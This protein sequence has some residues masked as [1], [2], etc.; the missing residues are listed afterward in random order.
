MESVVLEMIGNVAVLR[1]N[2][3]DVFNSFN[4]E[5]ALNLQKKLDACAADKNVRAIVLTGNGKAFCAGQDL[6]EAINPDGPGIE[7][8]VFEHYNPII[9]KIRSIEK[10][11]I[12]AV[13]G[14]AAGAGASLAIGCD[15]IL[16]SSVA[17]FTEAFSKIGL[18]PDT[19]G[20]YFLPR[21]IGYHRAIALMFTS[22]KI[23]AQEAMEMGIVWK[24]FDEATFWDETMKLA[25]TL[26]NMPTRGLGLTKKL[27][28]AG[29]D[30]N[31]QEQLNMEGKLQVEATHTYDYQEGVK[32]FLEKRKP[33][34]KGE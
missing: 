11:V 20:T 4:R 16:A 18:V 27:V 22:D 21:L 26:A 15:I 2:R 10:P 6:S 19:G 30:N 28:N 13:N 12:A 1:L 23:S 8:I 29:F 34:F 17:G 7:K 14:I 5:M 9:S 33:S 31:L 25:T 24:V 3:P 32:A